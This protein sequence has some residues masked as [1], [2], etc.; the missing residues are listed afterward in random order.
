MKEVETWTPERKL[1]KKPLMLELKQPISLSYWW[2][3]WIID[4]FKAT[5]LSNLMSLLKSQKTP[6]RIVPGPKSQRPKLLSVL[7]TLRPPKRL[8]KR[9]K[10]T[11]STKKATEPHEIEDHKEAPPQPPGSTTPS[12][13]GVEIHEKTRT[14]VAVRTKPRLPARIATKKATMQTSVQNLS[15]QK[16]S[17]GLGNLRFG[18]LC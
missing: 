16:T 9:K 11:V 13:L 4:S 1:F 10:T 14:E 3:K 12:S 6:I 18:D 2:E 8:G 5:A 7:I 17:I 15:S